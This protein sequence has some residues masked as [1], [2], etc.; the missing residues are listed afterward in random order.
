MLLINDKTQPVFPDISSALLS[1][2]E[3]VIET[4]A[5]KGLRKELGGVRRQ[6]HSYRGT[7]LGLNPSSSL[8]SQRFDCHH[9]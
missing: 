4:N 5:F 6:A 2:T 8:I 9:H 1:A 7:L 3:R